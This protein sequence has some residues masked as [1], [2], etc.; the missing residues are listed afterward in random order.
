MPRAHAIYASTSGNVELVVEHVQLQLQRELIECELHRA[1]ITPVEIVL[2]NNLFILATS[3]WEHGEINPFFDRLL[4]QLSD[5]NLTGKR[6]AFVG[7]GDKRYE[8]VL[9]CGGMEKLKKIFIRQGGRVIYEPLKLNGE[10]H[11]QLESIVDPWVKEIISEINEEA[12]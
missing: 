9:F 2:D 12:D 8:P 4:T 11:H 3:T 6:A 5:A 1:E 10:P 7:L